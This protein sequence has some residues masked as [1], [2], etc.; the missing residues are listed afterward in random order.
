MDSCKLLVA[1]HGMNCADALHFYILDLHGQQ[2]AMID[3]F[4]WVRYQPKKPN[5]VEH[6]SIAGGTDPL[7]VAHGGLILGIVNL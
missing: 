4:F 1:S 5:I 3:V 2:L 6:I 7:F